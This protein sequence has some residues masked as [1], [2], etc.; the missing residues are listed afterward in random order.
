MPREGAFDVF[1]LKLRFHFHAVI[2]EA[3]H[4][5]QL[6]EVLFVQHID[7]LFS[8]RVIDLSGAEVAVQYGICESELILVTHA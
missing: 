8:C 3:I 1:G 5:P 7:A 2:F 4:E 6:E